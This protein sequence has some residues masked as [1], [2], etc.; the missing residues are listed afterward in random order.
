MAD[1]VETD[2]KCTGELEETHDVATEV[3]TVF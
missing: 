1:E 2:T 3:V